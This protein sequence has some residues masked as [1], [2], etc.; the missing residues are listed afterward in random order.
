MN[1]PTPGTWGV[2]KLIHL[3]HKD[4][5]DTLTRRVD[6]AGDYLLGLIADDMARYKK[7]EFLGTIRVKLRDME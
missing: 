2:R 3:T 6:A 7:G 4:Q 1:S 5:I